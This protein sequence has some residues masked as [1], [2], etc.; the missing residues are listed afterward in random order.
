MLSCCIICR[1]CFTILMSKQVMNEWMLKFASSDLL[2]DELLR[3]TL[4][5]TISISICIK[6]TRGSTLQV[7]IGSRWTFGGEEGK[8]RIIVGCKFWLDLNECYWEKL[9]CLPFWFSHQGDKKVKIGANST[10]KPFF[11]WQQVDWNCSWGQVGRVSD[12]WL[13]KHGALTYSIHPLSFPPFLG[14]CYRTLFFRK[15]A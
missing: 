11:K 1:V 14:W 12:S 8:G 9:H 4:K 2:L 7:L 10:P 3:I 5:I 13:Y 6:P 15:L